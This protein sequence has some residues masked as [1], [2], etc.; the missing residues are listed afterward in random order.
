VAHVP[1][2]VIPELSELPFGSVVVFATP[3][4]YWAAPPTPPQTLTAVGS[5]Y[6]H[7]IGLP[8]EPHITF[9]P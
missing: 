6:E 2:I 4:L 1:N 7:L 8:N 5:A 3:V 9:G